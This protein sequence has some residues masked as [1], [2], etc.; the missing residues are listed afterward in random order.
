MVLSQTLVVGVALIMVE[1]VARGITHV[2]IE[3]LANFMA[4]MVI[5]QTTVG[6]NM[7]SRSSL[8]ILS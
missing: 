7:L 2:E 4:S 8:I 5:L 3:L 6:I 1:F